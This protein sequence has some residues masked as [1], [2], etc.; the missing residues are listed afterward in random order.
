V[1]GVGACRHSDTARSWDSGD[2]Q[3]EPLPLG[4]RADILADGT[5][6]PE[7]KVVPALLPA[8]DMQLQPY[9]RMS[10]LPVGLLFNFRAPRLEDGLAAICR[11]TALRRLTGLSSPW[12]TVALVLP[13]C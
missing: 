1:S 8:H 4:F 5:V 11:M 10:G 3:G 7:I 13:P 6:I 2:I 12:P 9:L